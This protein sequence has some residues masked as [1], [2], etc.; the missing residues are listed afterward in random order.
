MRYCKT[1]AKYLVY[2]LIFLLPWQTKLILRSGETNFTEISLYFSQLLFLLILVPFFI[3]KIKEKPAEQKTPLIWYFLG[4]LELFVLISFFFAPDKLLAFYHY[5]VF[6]MGLALFYFIRDGLERKNYQECYLDKAKI[7]YCFLSGVLL[8][9]FLGIYQFL[10]QKS[11]SFKYL[12][13]AAHDPQISGTSVVETLSGRWLR[14]YGGMD[15][16]NILGG[17]LV[18]ALILSAYLLAKKKIIRTRNEI[19]ELIFLFIVYFFSLFA[20]FFT[21]SRAAWLA[22]FIGF[23]ILLISLIKERDKFIIGRYIALLFFSLILIGITASPYQDLLKTRLL[24]QSRLEQKS[25]TERNAYI[26]EA[27]VVIKNNFLFGTGIGNYVSSLKNNDAIKKSAWQYQPVH[28]SFLLIFAEG[29][30]FSFL[31]FAGF[32]L[33]LPRGNFREKYSWAIWGALI[34]LLL[35]DHWLLSLPFGILFLFLSLGLI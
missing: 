26:S 24:V 14:A 6:L 11:F 17:I 23:I 31:F 30:I 25:I 5:V 7:I 16:P 27:G 35:L 10:S 28:N 9:A 21:F 20:L 15:H 18:I 3:Y 34:V 33:V 32:L 22:L 2:S 13:I 12:G 29:G 19:F 1:I 8:Q 4:G